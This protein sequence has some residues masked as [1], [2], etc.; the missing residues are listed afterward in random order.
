MPDRMKPPAW[1][2]QLL[3]ITLLFLPSSL[4]LAAVRALDPSTPYPSLSSLLTR[5]ASPPGLSDRISRRL[6]YTEALFHLCDMR[7]TFIDSQVLLTPAVL[8]NHKQAVTH[9]RAIG[10][11]NLRRSRMPKLIR[12]ANCQ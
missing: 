4:S 1:T 7:T 5:S 10:N 6:A 3:W 8:L 11:R 12:E 2:V 9:E